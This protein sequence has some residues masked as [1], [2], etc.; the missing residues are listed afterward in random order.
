[1]TPAARLADHDFITLERLSRKAAVESL[2]AHR[3]H[4]DDDDD[5]FDALA[6]HLLEIG[7]RAWHRFD[8]HGYPDVARETYA[9]R[10][11]RGHRA[12][13]FTDGPYLDWLRR[14]VRDHR[15]EPDVVTSLS[16]EGDLPETPVH[17]T[18]TVRAY[19]WTIARNLDPYN[20]RTLLE[21]VVPMIEDDLG[22]REAAERAG[23]TPGEAHDRIDS[24]ARQLHHLAPVS[25]A[26]TTPDGA[27][28]PAFALLLG[29]QE[30]A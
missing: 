14:T 16:S 18:E 25:R 9:Y 10:A 5:R 19:A 13:T 15:F 30:A 11:M 2:R 1:M 21:L 4:L 3:A 29:T 24:L 12:G 22:H 20:A 7:V 17:E 8:P 27:L 6:I 28:P 26:N 23:L